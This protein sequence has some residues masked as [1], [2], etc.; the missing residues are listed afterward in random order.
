[1]DA[2]IFLA[3]AD[4]RGCLLGSKDM[5]AVVPCDPR[6]NIFALTAID[7]A[8]H[9]YSLQSA[10]A[11]WLCLGSGGSGGSAPLLTSA[12]FSA[13]CEFCIDT[14]EGDSHAL[15]HSPQSA[16]PA[17]PY[18]R[19]IRDPYIGLITRE[20]AARMN[21]LKVALLW[22]PNV[23]FGAGKWLSACGSKFM[24]I[25]SWEVELAAKVGSWEQF[26]V[27]VVGQSISLLSVGGPGNAASRFPTIHFSTIQL[28]EEINVVARVQSS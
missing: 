14:R 24:G 26:T 25:G 18:W 2:P 11:Q 4:E 19:I 5:G 22:A 16:R 23:S 17:G 28:S 13:S 27:K 10:G 12:P 9:A 7:Q 20:H 8:R 1:M 15:L 21:G 3:F 6:V